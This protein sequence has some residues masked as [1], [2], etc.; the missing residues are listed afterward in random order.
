MEAMVEAGITAR[1][2]GFQQI[3]FL[4]YTGNFFN[5]LRSKRLQIGLI[6]LEWLI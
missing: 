5:P 1:N 4:S 6:V 2:H 3:L